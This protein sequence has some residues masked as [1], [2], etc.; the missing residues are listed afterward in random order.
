MKKKKIGLIICILLLLYFIGGIIYSFSGTSDKNKNNKKETG[1]QI[2]G[3]DYICLD[4]ETSLYKEEFKIL[5]NNLESDSINYKDYAYSI[6]KL[7]IIDLYDLNSKKNM[8]DVG[9]VD[10]VYPNARDNYK[11]NVENTL[12]KYMENNLDGERKQ[13]LPEVSSVQV[14]SNEEIEYNIGEEKFQGYK[15]N[16]DITYVKDLEYDKKAEVILV[17]QDKYLYVV[18][19]N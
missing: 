6:S 2:K 10:F 17:K 11:L 19:K 9:G 3:F 4:K 15:I 1:I 14:V 18:E 12:Y 13:T 16:L 5:K 7:F 8:Y